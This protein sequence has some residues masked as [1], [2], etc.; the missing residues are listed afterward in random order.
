MEY[1]FHFSN[2]GNLDK[3]SSFSLPAF[4]PPQT[5]AAVSAENHIRPQRAA[6][7]HLAHVTDTARMT[8]SSLFTC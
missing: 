6:M 7:A 5:A 3:E 1:K 4:I 8:P 2:L